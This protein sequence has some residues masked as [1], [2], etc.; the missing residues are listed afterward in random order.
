MAVRSPRYTS[1]GRD[2][3]SLR[4]WN[5]IY[6]GDNQNWSLLV[7]DIYV[8]IIGVIAIVIL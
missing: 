6:N 8:M 4:I 7:N 5:E 2:S 3:K 1:Q